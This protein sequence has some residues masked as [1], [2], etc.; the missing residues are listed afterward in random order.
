[1]CEALPE[2]PRWT[3]VGSILREA[4]EPLEA[5]AVIHLAFQLAVAEAVPALEYQELHHHH[6]VDVGSTSLGA[7]VVVERLDD[8]PEDFPDYEGFNFYKAVAL[9]V[10]LPV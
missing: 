5:G 8:G 1:L 6:R 2:L 7:L 4:E 3:V 9:L 10:D